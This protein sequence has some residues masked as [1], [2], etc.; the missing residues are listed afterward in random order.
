MSRILYDLDQRFR[1]YLI[2]RQTKYEIHTKWIGD[3]EF[4]FSKQFMFIQLTTQGERYLSSYEYK[5]NFWFSI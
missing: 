5:L 4:A 3:K 2:S 1:S